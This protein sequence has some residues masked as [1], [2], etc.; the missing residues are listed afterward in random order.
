MNPQR[1]DF[2]Q[3]NLP[4]PVY[5]VDGSVHV[6]IDENLV[7]AKALFPSSEPSLADRRDGHVNVQH[8]DALGSN[9]FHAL[10]FTKYGGQMKRVR[11]VHLEGTFSK[12]VR[13]DQ[14]IS[15]S[16]GYIDAYA[17]TASSGKEVYA[18]SFTGHL[19][20]EQLFAYQFKVTIE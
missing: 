17:Y 7:T 1:I 11:I 13:Q 8:F 16:L 4:R 2:R 19:G 14:E 6:D 12:E 18:G 9:L 3:L 15:V 10:M 5:L 20:G